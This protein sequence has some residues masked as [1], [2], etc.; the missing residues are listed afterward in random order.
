MR[1]SLVKDAL[2][3]IRQR[4]G[5]EINGI[6]TKE[7]VI[8]VGYTG[9]RISSDDIGLANTPLTDFSPESCNLFSRAGALTDL[10]ANELAELAQ[11]WD[12]SERVVGIAALNALSQL[13]IRTKGDD[14]IKKY[15]DAVDLAR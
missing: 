2:K 11:S 13:A 7:L 9:V 5:K 10:P 12:L 8:G 1:N 6:T 3:E 14:I 4:I 15:G